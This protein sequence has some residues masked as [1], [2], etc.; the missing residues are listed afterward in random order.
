MTRD[1]RTARAAAAGL[2][3][4]QISGVEPVL[5]YTRTAVVLH[6]LIAALV[7]V[8]VTWG[9]LMQEIPKS[10]P[11]VRADAFNVHKSIGLCL[12]TLMLI[13]L[14]W[15]LVHRPPAL[16]VMPRWQQRLAS[17]T[18][19]ALYACLFIMPLAGYLGSV[20]SGYPVKFFGVTLPAWGDRNDD[21]KEAMRA[22]HL[23]TSFVLVGLIALH[24][25]GAIHHALRGDPVLGRMGLARGA[26]SRVGLDFRLRRRET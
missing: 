20:W 21:L 7:V 4:K 26:K 17:A 10:P 8:Q 1:V 18:H 9:W 5:R 19:V 13:R 2:S 23:T 25:A 15:R 24:V 3:T 6:W 14:G 22:L 16:P 11:G 12:L